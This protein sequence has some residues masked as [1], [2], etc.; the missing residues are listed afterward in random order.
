VL[1]SSPVTAEM[2]AILWSAPGWE[3]LA[4]AEEKADSD[5]AETLRSLAMSA[6]VDAVPDCP[7]RRGPRTRYRIHPAIAEAIRAAMPRPV[8]DH[9]DQLVTS[10]W[11]TLGKM[12]RGSEDHHAET[13]T[14]AVQ[15]AFSAAPYLIRLKEW[16]GVGFLMD[17]ALR[18]EPSP[19]TAAAFDDW[20]RHC[21][22]LSRI[23]TAEILHQLTRDNATP[24]AEVTLAA[25]TGH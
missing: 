16:K 25:L 18:R 17:A 19:R 5:V 15:A 2:A 24:D 1:Y 3:D 20:E 12:A 22:A 13:T 21:A 11:F 4:G 8:R 6:L 14:L 23:V 10:Y 9:V 7:G